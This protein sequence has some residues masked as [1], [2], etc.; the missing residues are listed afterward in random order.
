VALTVTVNGE[1]REVAPATTIA[2][3]V[4]DLGLEPAA[5]AVERNGAIVPRMRLV[6]TLLEAGDRLE[7]VRFVQGG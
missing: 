7:V 3:L 5:V 6:S 4:E 2:D 1:L